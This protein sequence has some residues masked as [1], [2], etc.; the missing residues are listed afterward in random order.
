MMEGLVRAHD[1]WH[2]AG[3]EFGDDG[4][5]D[6]LAAVLG[7]HVDILQVQRKALPC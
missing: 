3:C 6:A 1:V 5:T 2:G 7:L 4:R